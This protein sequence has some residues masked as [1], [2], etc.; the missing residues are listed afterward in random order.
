MNYEKTYKE[1]LNEATITNKNRISMTE[2]EVKL[3]IFKAIA[4][5]SQ[6]LCNSTQ[7]MTPSGVA[8]YTNEVYEILTKKNN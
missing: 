7:N 4:N 2:I 1:A 8:T 3:E 5:N 6:N